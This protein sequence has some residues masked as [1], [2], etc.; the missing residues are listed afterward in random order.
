MKRSLEYSDT[1]VLAGNGGKPNGSRDD[2]FEIK[3]CLEQS[4]LS[5]KDNDTGE[6][7]NGIEDCTQ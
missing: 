5:I 1:I 4:K 3:W 6:Y 7:I 2:L